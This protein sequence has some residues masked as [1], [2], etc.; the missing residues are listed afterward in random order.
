MS[1]ENNAY[2]SCYSSFVFVEMTTLLE[3][4]YWLKE[5]YRILK[6]D[7]VIIITINNL[8][9]VGIDDFKYSNIAKFGETGKK[10]NIGDPF[11]ITAYGIPEKNIP[12]ISFVDYYWPKE[13]F[14]KALKE[15]GFKDYKYEV[16][17]NNKFII[18]EIQH[19]LK[20]VNIVDKREIEGITGIITAR[21]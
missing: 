21:K 17:R 2:I 7:G 11:N 16:Q 13:I 14:E 15:I 8:S 9:I 6:N 20:Y 19:L 12:D 5:I 1:L 10:Y 4:E 18:E 3:I